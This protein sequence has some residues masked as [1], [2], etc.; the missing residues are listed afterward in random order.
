MLHATM[1]LS[2]RS[3]VRCCSADAG[4][5]NATTVGIQPGLHFVSIAFSKGGTT[6]HE[7]HGSR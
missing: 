5:T 7:V 2:V 3:C 1:L 6:S 4:E